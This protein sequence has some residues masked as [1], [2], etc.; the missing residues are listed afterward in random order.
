MIAASCFVSYEEGKHMLLV[1]YAGCLACQS[2]CLLPWVPVCG[3]VGQLNDADMLQ[4][5]R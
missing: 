2:V 3:P 4:G 5:H 1:L